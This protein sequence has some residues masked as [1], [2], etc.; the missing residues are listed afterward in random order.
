MGLRARALFVYGSFMASH[1][2]GRAVAQRSGLKG[3]VDDQVLALQLHEEDRVRRARYL[4]AASAR[5]SVSM[6]CGVTMPR[7]SM[8]LLLNC[9][10]TPGSL[11]SVVGSETGPSGPRIRDHLAEEARHFD[12]RQLRLY[13][14]THGD[15]AHAYTASTRRAHQLQKAA[16]VQRRRGA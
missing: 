9:G 16:E 2:S 10:A 6:S 8:P 7:S 15:R 11:P 12:D 3:H 13:R 14:Y 4:A 1:R 5:S